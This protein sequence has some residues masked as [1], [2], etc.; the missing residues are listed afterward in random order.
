MIH[1]RVADVVTRRKRPRQG[2]YASRG[3]SLIEILVAL[4]IMGLLMGVVGPRVLNYLTDARSKTARIQ[5]D[6]LSSALDLF[7]IDTGRYPSGQEGIEALVRRPADAGTWNGPYLKGTDVPRDPWGNAYLYRVPGPDGPYE[8]I[9][10][11]SD[12]REGGEGSAADIS[13]AK[14]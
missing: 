11:G 2:R 3:F 6:N 14:R 9:S 5:I 13:S 4:V 7:F 1:A 12:G 8:L 10:L